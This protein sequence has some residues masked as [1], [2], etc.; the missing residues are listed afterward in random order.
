VLE[1]ARARIESAGDRAA[2]EEMAERLWT[3]VSDRSG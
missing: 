2:L 3:G 1:D